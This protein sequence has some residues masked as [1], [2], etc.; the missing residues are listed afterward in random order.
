MLESVED[1]TDEVY[2]CGTG[3]A[4]TVRQFCQLAFQCIDIDISFEGKGSSEKDL[5]KKQE[6]N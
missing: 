1:P 3:N 6:N 4:S 2:C 5:I